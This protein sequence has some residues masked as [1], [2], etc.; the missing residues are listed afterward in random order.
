M[1]YMGGSFE[2][3]SVVQ[4]LEEEIPGAELATIQGMNMKIGVAL[5]QDGVTFGR[6]EGDDPSNAVFAPYNANDPNM[7][8]IKTM[9]D[10]DGSRLN[11]EEELYV[12]WPDV[13]VNNVPEEDRAPGMAQ[14]N[15]YMFYSTMLKGSKQKSIG[16]AVSD[17]GFKWMH[18]GVAIMPDEGT[19]DEGGCARCCV[20]RK[21]IH[22]EASGAWVDEDEWIMYYEGVSKKDGKHRILAAESKDLRNWKKIGISLDIGEQG[23]WDSYGVGAPHLIRLDDGSTRMYYTGQ[24]ENGNTAIGVAKCTDN[25]TDFTREKAGFYL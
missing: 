18:R 10:D 7:K 24:C 3:T 15:F 4:Y 14:R 20:V 19:L 8:Y 5:S 12:A 25:M 6:V 22:N 1:Y 11:I 13:V 21:A 17:D 16:V 2:E 9:R 23:S